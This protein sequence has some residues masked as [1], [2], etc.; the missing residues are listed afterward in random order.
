MH[1]RATQAHWCGDPCKQAAYRMRKEGNA[2]R[3]DHE[4]T[5][6]FRAPTVERV[7]RYHGAFNAPM[8]LVVFDDGQTVRTG[9]HGITEGQ[10][11]A[12]ARWKLARRV[13]AGGLETTPAAPD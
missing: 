3:E 7:E 10:A 9:A 12:R 5:G 11:R 6:R 1:D 13:T 8:W 2:D 4:P